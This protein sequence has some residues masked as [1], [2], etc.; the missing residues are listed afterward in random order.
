MRESQHR[1]SKGTNTMETESQ[2]SSEST[3]PN[4]STHPTKR[5]RGRPRGS[6]NKKYKQY[7][8]KA[9]PRAPKKVDFFAPE[10]VLKSTKKRGRP[11]KIKIRGRPRK[12]PLTPEEE[13]EIL[14]RQTLQRKRKLSKPLGR[15]RIH[16]VAVTPKIKR[17]RGRPRK[18]EAVAGSPSQNDTDSGDKEYTSSVEVSIEGAYDNPRKRGRPLGS[19]KKKR[20]RPSSSPKV[21]TKKVSDG[22]PRKRGRPPGSGSKVKIAKVVSGPP[23]KRGRPPGSTNK[24]KIVRREADGTP[25]KRGRPKGSGKKITV[26]KK[27]MGGVPRKRGRP[28]GSGKI[29]LCVPDE[30]D[31]DLCNFVG[32]SHHR[33]RG[34]PSKVRLAVVLEKLPSSY[35]DEDKTEVDA[36]SPKRICDSDSPSQVPDESTEG[37]PT[38]EVKEPEV[39]DEGDNTVDGPKVNNISEQEMG[40]EMYS[41]VGAG[42]F[43]KKK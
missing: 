22:I 2:D 26:V 5:G 17:G 7:M 42:K 40:E 10:T 16:P 34:R 12:V 9:S 35:T 19:F 4:G 31:L 33:K 29:K 36:P 8:E 3:L 39:S 25:R 43:K 41:K 23:R 27:D 21:P 20:G 18:Y 28:P 38:S 1:S 15:P 14:R 24:V 6:L 30:V 13:S 11:K 32:T 37:N